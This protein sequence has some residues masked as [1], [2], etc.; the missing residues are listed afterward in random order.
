M[1]ALT[2]AEIGDLLL[3]WEDVPPP[4]EMLAIIASGMRLWERPRAAP[5][6][7]YAE[8]RPMTLDEMRGLADRLNGAARMS[9]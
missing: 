8:V 3:S 6:G 5:S 4:G 9:G 1:D 2:L 7:N